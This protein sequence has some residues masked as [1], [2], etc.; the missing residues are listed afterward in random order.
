MGKPKTAVISVYNKSWVTTLGKFLAEEGVVI[1]SSGGTLAEL[2]KKKVPA[3]PI[4]QLTGAKEIL[5]GRVKTLQYG[6]YAGLLADRDNAKHKKTLGD[7]GVPPIDIVVVNFYPFTEKV[8][9]KTKMNDARELI[10][11]GGVTLVRAAAKNFQHVIPIVDPDDY[12][13][14][15]QAWKEHDGEL[16]DALRL[17]YATKAFGYCREYDLAIEEYFKSAIEAAKPAGERQEPQNIEMDSRIDLGLTRQRIL[18]YGENP[19]QRAALYTSTQGVTL[20]FRVLHNKD[21]SYNNLQDAAAALRLCR[22]PYEKKHVACVIK[23]MNPCGAANEDNPIK[24]IQRAKEGDPVSAYGGILGVSFEVGIAEAKEISKTF[25]EVIIAPK[26]A[27]DAARELAA[28]KKLRLVETGEDAFQSERERILEAIESGRDVPLRFASTPFGFLVQEED[29]RALKPNEIEVVSDLPLR[30]PNKPDMMFGL[31]VIR[32]LKSNSIALFKDLTMVGAGMGQP[33]RVDATKIAL[34]KAGKRASG[35]VMVS[36]GFFP[37]ADSVE[38]AHKAG[39]G[40][41]V[42]PKGSIRDH[43]VIQ[44]ANDLKMCLVFVA[45]RHFL[46]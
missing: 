42:A 32:F 22:M 30:P 39:V 5:D 8:R 3:K 45:Q 23:H 38:L 43:E 12:K 16:P 35:A 37:F 33:S 2:K 29:L 13:A 31:T 21:L 34:D 36:D 17:Q 10:D 1:Y 14:F 4:E 15:A 25:L 41:L 20:P 19:H 28:K 7:I 11:I 18:R 40:M 24:A 44:R 27:P 26:F 46:H 9:S 6:L